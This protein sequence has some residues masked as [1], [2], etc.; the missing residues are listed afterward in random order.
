[1]WI[2]AAA[3]LVPLSILLV[4]QYLW[5]VDLERTSTVARRVA[6]DKHLMGVAKEVDYFYSKQAKALNLPPYS[7][8]RERLHKVAHWYRKEPVLG[9]REVFLVLYDED[10]WGELFVLDPAEASLR[11]PL[12]WSPAIHAISMAVAPWNILHRRGEK[13]TQPKWTVDER[14]PA[15]RVLLNPVVDEDDRLVGLAGMVLDED[16]LLQEILPK[17]IA[18]AVPEAVNGCDLLVTLRDGGGTPIFPPDPPESRGVEVKRR[19]ATAFTDWVLTLESRTST[20]EQWARTN[21][22]VNI[23]LSAVLGLVLLAGTL[24]VLRTAAREMRLSEMKSDFVSNVS[25]ELR[26]PLASIRVFAE[27]MRLGRVRRPEKVREYGE[28]IETES[29]RLSQLINNILDFSKIESGGRVYRLV[30]VDLEEL[31]ADAVRTFEVRLR[32]SG[33]TVLLHRPAGPLPSVPVDAGAITQA[34]CNLVDNAVKYSNGSKRVEVGLERDRDTDY[35]GGGVVIWVR[36]G[37]I[38]I[39][40][41]EQQKIFDRFHRVGSSLVHDVKGSGLGLAIVQHIALAHDGKVTVESAPGE[42]STFRVHL[43][44]RPAS[45]Q[46]DQKQTEEDRAAAAPSRGAVPAPEGST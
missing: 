36:D 44:F 5:L 21:F 13:V 22:A 26:T 6:L 10:P 35:P 43:P 9:A 31:V 20:S 30:P 41:D 28:Y 11:P 42:G 14:D 25:H 2:A 38:G 29:R 24:L 45:F 18:E 8:D 17:A 12:E 23:T 34:V 3:V 40:R 7:F 27:L 33:F 16:Y 19:L 39:S 32:H 15:N 37:G 1:V 46:Q 4:L